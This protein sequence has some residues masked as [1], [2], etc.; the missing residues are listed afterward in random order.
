AETERLNVIEN[1]AARGAQLY[2]GCLK[3][4]DK[5][6]VVGDVRGGYG[7]MTAIEMVGDRSTKKPIDPALANQMQEVAYQSGALLRVSGP[8]VILS[9]PL[10]LSESDAQTILTAM[11]SGLASL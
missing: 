7:L 3:L 10:V 6:D 2:Q 1:A 8:N 5:Y 4:K 9:P 11:D